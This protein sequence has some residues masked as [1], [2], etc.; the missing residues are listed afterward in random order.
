MQTQRQAIKATLPASEHIGNARNLGGDKETTERTV[1][2]AY[3]QADRKAAQARA[4][5]NSWR[6]SGD[7][8]F[9][10]VV[11]ARWYMARRGDGASTVY[12]SVWITA[13]DGRS[14]SGHGKAGGYGYH[15]PSE[16]F[17]QALRSAGLT[18]TYEDGTPAHIGGA[19]DSLVREA[20]HAVACAAGYARNPRTLV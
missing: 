1:L 12:C 17:A 8:G 5:A 2:L 4:A 9:A 18:L 3:S 7:E 20:M 6:C 19:G 16:A 14:W 13:R 10:T 11:D 15:K